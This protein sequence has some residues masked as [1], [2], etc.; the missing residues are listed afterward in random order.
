MTGVLN[1][2]LSRGALSSSM[3]LGVVTLLCKDTSRAQEPDA[4]RPISLLSCDYKV[5]AKALL[6]RIALVLDDV[7][8]PSQACS[9]PGRSA[10]LHRLALRDAA[11]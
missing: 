4:Y 8:H 10:D 11:H 1:T 9:V 7:L 6:S 3:R 2:C 5:L